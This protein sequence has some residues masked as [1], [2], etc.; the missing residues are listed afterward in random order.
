MS[1]NAIWARIRGAHERKSTRFVDVVTPPRDLATWAARAASAK[2]G[3][4]I[5]VLDVGEVITITDYFVIVSGTS[6]RH[7]A[8]VAEEV[9]RALK[10]RGVR[11]LR[12]EGEAGA[13]WILL[14]YVDFVVHLFHQEEREFYR[15]ERLWADAPR[16]EWEEEVRAFSG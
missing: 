16:L 2:L 15:L 7:V 4:D 13:R 14:D 3:E 9:T 8:T 6:D 12:R 1:A 11:P 5:V 10:E